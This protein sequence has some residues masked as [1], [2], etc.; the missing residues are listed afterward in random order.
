VDEKNNMHGGK[1]FK[2]IYEIWF[3]SSLI[4]FYEDK[5][6]IRDN[7]TYMVPGGKVVSSKTYE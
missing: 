4:C 5:C 6:M 1:T 7:S 3:E 2:V